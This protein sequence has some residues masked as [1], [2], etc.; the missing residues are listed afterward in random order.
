[1]VSIDAPRTHEL[2]GFAGVLAHVLAD[3]D[4]SIGK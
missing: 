3:I 2:G 1:M 4:A